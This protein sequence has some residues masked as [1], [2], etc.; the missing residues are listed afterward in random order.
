MS[1][2]S[3]KKRLFTTS[4]S[5]VCQKSLI[6]GSRKRNFPTRYCLGNPRDLRFQRPHQKWRKSLR[7]NRKCQRPFTLIILIRLW[8]KTRL[9]FELWP[10]QLRRQEW[11]PKHTTDAETIRL[12]F[13]FHFNSFIWTSETWTSVRWYLQK[14]LFCV[15]L[16]T[17]FI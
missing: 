7:T 1:F 11:G 2:R 14:R 13:E 15:V 12:G 6:W 17:N 9:G 4:W 3:F 10:S 8:E 16:C 5:S